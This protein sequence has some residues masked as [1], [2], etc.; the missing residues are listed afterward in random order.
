VEVAKRLK[1]FGVKMLYNKHNRLSEAQEIELGVEYASFDR[2]ITDSDILT[3]H[4]PLTSETQG[5]IGESQIAKMKKGAY[6]VNTARGQIVDEAAVA[7]AL[8]KGKLSGAAFD[9]PRYGNEDIPN[10]LSTF[11][12]VKNV[13]VTPHTSALSPES[14]ERCIKGFTRN[15]F[16]A[17]RGEKPLNIV[18]G[19]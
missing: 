17:L 10:L 14:M 13:F 12:G 19:I 1:P 5:M 3:I 16:K 11:Q 2:L 15:I 9:V 18:N 4:V 6:L 7:E 8:R